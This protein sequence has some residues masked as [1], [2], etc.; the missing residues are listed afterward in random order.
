[1]ERNVLVDKFSR[2]EMVLTGNICSSTTKEEPPFETVKIVHSTEDE[3]REVTSI[4]DPTMQFQE[5]ITEETS[6]MIS[7]DNFTKGNPNGMSAVKDSIISGANEFMTDQ[8]DSETLENVEHHLRQVF[9][10]KNGV[11]CSEV[12][13]SFRAFMIGDGIAAEHCVLE[14]TDLPNRLQD[15]SEKQYPL[16]IT[17]KYFWLMLDATLGAPYYFERNPGDGSLKTD[18]KGWTDVDDISILLCMDEDDYDSDSTDESENNDTEHD[19]KSENISQKKTR[20]TDPRREVTYNVFE[21]LLWPQMIGKT[22]L[23]KNRYHPLLIWTE[24]MSFIKGSFEALASK[25]DYLSKAEYFEMGRKQAPAFVGDRETLYELFLI[26]EH[27]RQQKCLFDQ[28]DVVKNLYRRFMKQKRRKWIVHEIYVDEAQD[29][30]QS[31]LFLLINLC[32]SPSGMFL[33]GDTAQSIMKGV[34]FRFKDLV[35]L[36]HYTSKNLTVSVYISYNYIEIEQFNM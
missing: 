26:Y 30:T 8:V 23:H 34:S 18:I 15:L 14:D 25:K 1:M 2:Y 36:F 32:E 7:C 29:F 22:K 13:K 19:S 33:T 9:I 11:L 17:A 3:D 10:T 28:T 4:Q 16:F 5:D 20:K 35:S 31:E 6:A 24:I 21:E 27:M 12:R